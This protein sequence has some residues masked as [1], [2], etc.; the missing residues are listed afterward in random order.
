[1][2]KRISALLLAMVIVI[3]SVLNGN[4]LKVKAASATVAMSPELAAEFYMVLLQVAETAMHVSG[5]NNGFNNKEAMEAIGDGVQ[6]Y[7]VTSM[8]EGV[9]FEFQT[10]DGQTF[11]SY[12]NSGYRGGLVEYTTADGQ[13]YKLSGDKFTSLLL[14]GTITLDPD[15][16]NDT[17]D[18]PTVNKDDEYVKNMKAMFD[19]KWEELKEIGF[20]DGSGGD[21]TPSPSPDPKKV[22]TKIA[23]VSLGASLIAVT[24]AFVKDLFDGKVDGL[25]PDTYYESGFSSNLRQN[26]D[27]NY[28]YDLS[29]VSAKTGVSYGQT[30]SVKDYDVSAHYRNYK[31]L[32]GTLTTNP[33]TKMLQLYIYGSTAFGVLPSKQIDI[34][35]SVSNAGMSSSY[36]MYY[37]L[38]SESVITDIPLFSSYDYAKEY[39]LSQSLTG[40][41]NGETYDFP[42]LVKSVPE[43]LQPLTGTKFSPSLLPGIN[44]AVSNAVK[45]LPETST[46]TKTNT[47]TYKETMTS[48]ITD[49][50]PKT[51]VVPEPTTK[52]DTD[53]DTGEGESYKRDLRL[54]FPFC[55][56]F[57]FIHFI[58]AL[59]AD[60][61]APCFKI[62]IKLDSL[63]IDMV[64]ELDLAWMD[65]V[66]EIFRLGELG[67]F[68]IMLMAATKK[69]IGW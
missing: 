40:L 20:D 63:G 9:D 67:C 61:V 25:D 14:N 48:T 30:Y 7:F 16:Y 19:A 51:E 5:A 17:E 42:D 46:D 45:S 56:P 57:D 23:L 55:I 64:L 50:A 53:T 52:P 21:P 54:I 47:E 66:M 32:V 12:S 28:I 60:P 8:S 3:G 41:L 62:P 2:Q 29:I 65:P 31:I 27:G 58:K 11:K 15:I 18:K 44:T 59:S 36:P 10:T 38:N 49:V 22:F 13:T 4:T 33:N 69:M 1:M 68:V 39:C 26:I 34:L 37:I 24:G 43:V 6:G 35:P